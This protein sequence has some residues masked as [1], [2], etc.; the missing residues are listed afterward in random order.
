VG[1]LSSPSLYKGEESTL[2]LSLWERTKERERLIM[3]LMKREVMSKVTLPF[4]LP[5]KGGKHTLYFLWERACS[6][7][8]KK[9]RRGYNEQINLFLSLWERIKERESL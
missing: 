2:F 5:L 6:E 4:I 3:I 1:R 8:M 7:F 9:L